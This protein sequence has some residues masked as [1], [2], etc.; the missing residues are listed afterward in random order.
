MNNLITEN[1]NL[2]I[3]DQIC[4]IEI[5]NTIVFNK[6]NINNNNNNNSNSSIKKCL[7]SSFNESINEN[8]ILTFE[9][10]PNGTYK[11]YFSNEIPNE[12]QHL[13][14]EEELYKQFIVKINNKRLPIYYQ[15][16]LI[17]MILS[18]ILIIPLFFIV[19]TFSPRL[20]FGICLT[21]LFYIAIFIL[22]NGLIEKRIVL[23]LTYFVLYKKKNYKIEEIILNYNSF[24]INKKIPILFRL[25][26]KEN[27]VVPGFD[28][29]SIEVTFINE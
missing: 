24:L 28:K 10:Q 9:I 19:F 7:K 14:V 13:I 4:E 15:I 20:A 17:L 8:N 22:T 26:Y 21:L 18:M 6:N 29:I 25:I 27:H 11:N 16:M 5:K 3:K 23:I 2:N 12:I 1:Q